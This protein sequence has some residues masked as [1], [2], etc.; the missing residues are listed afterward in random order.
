MRTG[1]RYFVSYK[2]EDSARVGKIVYPLHKMGIPMWYDYGIEKGERWSRAINV[3]IREC[4]AVLMFAT[5]RL[6]ASEDPYVRKEY[7]IAMGYHKKIFVIWMDDISF[8]DVH[9]NLKDWFVDVEELQG[10]RTDNKTQAEI[11]SYLVSEFQLERCIRPND[12]PAAVTSVPKADSISQIE[13]RSPSENQYNQKKPVDQKKPEIQKLTVTAFSIVIGV[14]LAS[15]LLGLLV[16]SLL[17]ND[18]G[19]SANEAGVIVSETADDT[20]N[21]FGHVYFLNDAPEFDAAYQ[22]F[23]TEFTDGTGVMV[24]TLT[25][26]EGLYE[27]KLSSEMAK[28]DFPTLF[29]LTESDL[30]EWSEYCF[31][32]SDSDVYKNLP[33]DFSVLTDGNKICGIRY[34]ADIGIYPSYWCVNN[35]SDY[36]DTQSTLDFLNAMV[37]SDHLRDVLNGKQEW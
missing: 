36:K 2:T 32:L 22:N 20:A 6:F 1:K 12:A 25:T 19:N 37:Y 15:A 28:S 24:L 29:K 27:Q 34:N 10:I 16:S 21:Q 31:D 13:H 4:E 14:V 8:D 33:E 9:L 23:S 17:K 7:K 30:S 18:D 11:P 26:A 35:N 3:N 5:K